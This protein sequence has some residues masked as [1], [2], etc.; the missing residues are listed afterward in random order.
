M[1]I[2]QTI[3]PQLLPKYYQYKKND[4]ILHQ[5]YSFNNKKIMLKLLHKYPIDNNNYNVH[6]TSII[7][8]IKDKEWYLI[9]INIISN[10]NHQYQQ[11]DN[12]NHDQLISEWYINRIKRIII[13]LVEL[14]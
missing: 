8:L 1:E 12:I 9:L 14:I 10:M 6:T 3:L 2:N 5:N 7:N 4:A 13:I 11:L